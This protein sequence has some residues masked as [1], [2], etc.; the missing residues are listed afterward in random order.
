M[1]KNTLK[2]NI[3]FILISISNI[4]ICQNQTIRLSVRTGGNVDF[5]FNSYKKFDQGIVYTDYTKLAVYYID[6]NNAGNHTALTHW[7]LDFKANSANIEG[8]SSNLDLRTL[9]LTAT[10]G[11]GTLP[12]TYLGKK[13]LSAVDVTLVNAGPEGDYN[14]NLIN[15]TYD[16]G[17]NATYKV[18]NKKSD[19][20]IVDIIF[21]V[22]STP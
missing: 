17:T 22:I 5:I 12:A 15:I 1:I 16:C 7:K 8:S 4:S 14:D 2:I 13:G 19:Y 3:L 20:F 9:E 6:T 10:D 18:L 21:T 11:G